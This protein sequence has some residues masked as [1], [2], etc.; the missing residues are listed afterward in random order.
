M[1][2]IAIA[3]FSL[4]LWIS[5]ADATVIRKHVSIAIIGENTNIIN[6]HVRNASFNG[7]KFILDNIINIKM[8]LIIV[9]FSF[10]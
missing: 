3:V 4:M 6:N 9:W 8:V 7:H 10:W 5:A 1:L 2:Q